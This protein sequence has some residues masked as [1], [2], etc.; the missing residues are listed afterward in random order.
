MKICIKVIMIFFVSVTY[1]SAGDDP[2]LS[3][4]N[5]TPVTPVLTPHHEPSNDDPVVFRSVVQ[6][7]LS[8]TRH[9]YNC[10]AKLYAVTCCAC[11]PNSVPTSF[12]PFEGA[13]ANIC[14]QEK[15]CEMDESFQRSCSASP[16]ACFGIPTILWRLFS[17]CFYDCVTSNPDENR[18]DCCTKRL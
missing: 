13:R 8:V 6:S 7:G 16:C 5:N 12:T 11:C 14:K 15:C 1:I 17:N 10:C 4:H 9:E 3:K 2:V 18:G